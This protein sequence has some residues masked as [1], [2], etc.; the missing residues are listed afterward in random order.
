MSPPLAGH[1]NTYHTYGFDEALDG[2]A[3]AGYKGVELSAVPGWTEHVT[4]NGQDEVRRKLAD[5]GLTAVSLSAHS[6]LTTREGLEH[7]IRGVR[8]AAEFGIPVV[9]T[10]VGGHQSAD[11][12]EAAFLANIGE[13]ADAADA[14]GVVVALEIHGDI[15]A[16]SE[17]TLP[18]LEKIGR[19][20]VKVNYD[21][22]NVEFYSGELAV[23]DLPKIVPHLAHVH[24]KDT[25]GGK[26]NWN[27]PAVGEG[28][29]DFARVLEILRDG[30]Y[31][32]PYSVELEFTGEPWPPLEEVDRSMRSSYEHLRSLGLT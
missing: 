4:L 21:T 28:T 19:D 24:L 22:A 20:S 26:G 17:V 18:L 10:A 31:D 27:F 6:D 29:I 16:S 9:N 3:R 11:E 12:N 1:T 7:G 23:D 30:G 32:G 15:M 25:T 13:L 8:W 5:R 2:I 14:A